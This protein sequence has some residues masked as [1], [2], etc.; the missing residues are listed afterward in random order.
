MGHQEVRTV[1]VPLPIEN[2]GPIR[3]GN[4]IGLAELE[5]DYV[6]CLQYRFQIE[7]RS[8]CADIRAGTLH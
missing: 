7:G 4:V 1:M 3:H 6:A 2:P 5:I 8:G